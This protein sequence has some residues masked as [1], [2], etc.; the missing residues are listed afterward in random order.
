[1]SF[2]TSQQTLGATIISPANGETL[3]TYE[4]NGKH[5]IRFKCLNPPD[6]A[7]YLLLF[8]QGECWP[9]PG[10]FR[11]VEDGVWEVDAYFGGTGDHTLYLVTANDLGR[12]LVEYYRK[13]IGLNIGRRKKLIEKYGNEVASLLGGD[14][15]GI[16]MN[17]VT[18]GFR[19][20][21]TV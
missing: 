17:G 21:A 19:L 7:N 4:S 6:S 14:Y 2:I 3:K 18:K 16:P 13:V 9:Q 10:A 11:Q 15:T 20:E 12:T 8:R 5:V 1:T